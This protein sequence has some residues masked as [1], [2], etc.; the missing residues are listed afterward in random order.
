[1]ESVGI[2][3]AAGDDVQ[4]V[5][6]P[7]R[8]AVFCDG[9]VLQE[10]QARCLRALLAQGMARLELVIVAQPALKRPGRATRHGSALFTVFRKLFMHAKATRPVDPADLFATVPVLSLRGENDEAS[11]SCRA[12][13]DVRWISEQGLDFILDFGFCPVPEALL[14]A[15]RYGVWEFHHGDD[16]TYRGGPPGFWEIHDGERVTGA[17]LRRRTRRPDERVVLKKG[18]FQTVDYSYA[19]NLDAILF[20]SASW[21]ARVCDDI[22]RGCDSYLLAPPVGTAAPVRDLPDHR[23]TVSFVQKVT[24][25]IARRAFNRLARR[26]EWNIGIV[27]EPAD[28]FLQPDHHP[29]VDWLPALSKDGFIADPFSIEKDGR[30]H[31]FFEEYDQRL[32]KGVISHIALDGGTVVSPRRRVLDLPV[33]LSYPY[34]F[35]NDGNVYCLPETSGA[36][37][38]ALYQAVNFPYE[39]RKAAVLVDDIA[40]ADSTVFEFGGRWWLFCTDVDAGENLRLFIWH[41]PELFGRW[42]PHAANP[43]KTD[44]RSSRPAGRPFTRD[45]ALF[46]PA[47]DCS[48][49]YGGG[50]TLNRVTTLTPEAFVEEPVTVMQPDPTGDYPDGIHTL[51]AA[52]DLTFVDGKRRVFRGVPGEA[53]ARRLLNAGRAGRFARRPFTRQAGSPALQGRGGPS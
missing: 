4:F 19:A 3:V 16:E 45:G 23:E 40:A 30:I 44:I 32:G 11:D 46:R 20:G 38:I 26:A 51:S 50:I 1:M 36:R 21:P 22:R 31:L 53:L 47:Q 2:S 39:W 6:C 10:W 12:V 24:G 48:R 34:V 17:V 35:E 14:E 18:F 52:G 8:F 9:M 42:Q 27:H 37:E 49:T 7:V 15:A 29:S 43:V 41:A 25:N 13:E 33:H 28:C 5:P